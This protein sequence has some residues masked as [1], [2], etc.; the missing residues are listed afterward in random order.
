M[1][2]ANTRRY[3]LE[4]YLEPMREQPCQP[5]RIQQRPG[6]QHL[7]A[8]Q[9]RHFLRH[10]RQYV[11][12]IRHEQENG[13]RAD[14]LHPRKHRV[15]NPVVS[16]DQV[17]A[18]VARPLLG[19]GRDDGD[20]GLASI[21]EGALADSHVGEERAIRQ[22]VHLRATEFVINVDEDQVADDAA[23]NE[24]VCD[25]GSDGAGAD[26]GDRVG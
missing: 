17:E 15:Q 1:L 26:D 14:R 12:G 3:P 25:G 13:I 11:D 23:E 2:G 4:L 18:S 24:G 19:A 10:G 8:R 16:I 5:D 9:A 20:F 6:P 21:F 22:V 7:F